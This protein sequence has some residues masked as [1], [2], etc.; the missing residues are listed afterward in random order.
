MSKGEEYIK[1]S[2]SKA[3]KSE[4]VQD[5]VREQLTTMYDLGHKAGMRLVLGRMNDALGE[6]Q[7]LVTGMNHFCD[8]EEK[9][10]EEKIKNAD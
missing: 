2:I 5:M 3:M 8:E 6:L 7:K 4:G 9:E 1:E 10:F